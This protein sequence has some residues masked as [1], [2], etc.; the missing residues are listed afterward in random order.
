MATSDQQASAPSSATPVD[1]SQFIRTMAK[2]MAALGAGGGVSPTPVPTQP[3]KVVL[4]EAEPSFWSTP[5]PKETPAEIVPLPTLEEAAAITTPAPIV[6]PPAPLPAPTDAERAATLERLRRKVSET[7]QMSIQSTPAPVE[8]LEPQQ[9]APNEWPDIPTPPPTFAPEAAEVERIPTLTREVPEQDTP[10]VMHTFSS[11]FANRIDQKNAST[12]SVLAA[13]QDAAPL[14]V[15]HA[16]TPDTGNKKRVITAVATGVVLL[17]LAGGGVYATYQFVMGMRN[18]PV[19]LVTVPSIV[20]AD[21][22][23]EL[24]GGGSVL[25]GALAGSANETLVAGN[26]LVTYVSEP[27]SGEGDMLLTKPAQGGALITALALPAPDILIRNI[28]SEST[29]GVV[30]ARSQ[31]RAFFAL[32]VES[33]ERTYAGMLTWEPR[34]QRDLDVLYPLYPAASV[35]VP[36]AVPASLT[37]TTTVSTSTP[38]FVDPVPAQARTRFDDAVVA[39]HDVR[40]LRDTAGNALLLYG[41]ADKQTLLIVRDEDAFETLLARLKNRE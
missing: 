13:Q 39:N 38:V 27:L 33:Y 32:R 24:S 7:A 1:K 20:F 21:E 40:I 41:Y 31:T 10:E 8:H 34:M 11:D 19:T 29:V 26:V 9:P 12:F 6:A 23:K 17:V 25:M 35:P 18:T 28:A 16:L 36:E 5:Q 15:P 22:Y 4:P 37:A 2:D 30:N 3:Q 14:P